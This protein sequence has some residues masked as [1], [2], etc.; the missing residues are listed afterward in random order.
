[1]QKTTYAKIAALAA[2]LTLIV[3]VFGAYVRLSN[4]GLGCPDWPGCYGHFGVPQTAEEIAQANISHP[5]RPVEPAKAWKEMYH[6]YLASGLGVLILFLAAI[7]WL[8]GSANFP[9]LLPTILVF[10]VIFQGL[11]GMWT[12]TLLVQPIIVTAHLA[13]GLLTL[14]LLWWLSLR[15]GQWFSGRITPPMTRLRPWAWLGLIILTIQVLLGGW[16]STNYASAA[17]IEFPTCYGGQWMPH[18]N[19]ADAFTL[20]QKLPTNVSSYEGGILE[21]PARVTIHVIHRIGA[22]VTFIYLLILSLQIMLRAANISQI[23]LGIFMHL[24]I[25]IQ[26]GLGIAIVLNFN[27]LEVAVAHNKVAALLL[28][29]MVTLIHILKPLR[30][31]SSTEA[32][33][34]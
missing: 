18:F 13:G 20:W 30:D 8:N 24:L 15:T 9:V 14:M 2:L 12:V 26:A 17:C 6:R 7:S 23:M 29:S 33:T 31:N 19:L 25:F 3:V 1:M 21:N 5:Q 27:Q 32:L 4:A 22:F 28:L 16:T 10:L 11:L 34:K